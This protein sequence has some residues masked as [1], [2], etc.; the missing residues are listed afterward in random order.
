M[1]ENITQDPSKIPLTQNQYKGTPGAYDAEVCERLLD[2]WD[3][4][5]ATLNP[6]VLT[7]NNFSEY[8]QAFVGDIA[9]IGSQYKSM[10]AN[11]EDLVADID[12]S[13]QE[14]QGVSS[15][16]EL[17]NM[18]MYQH[19]YNANSRYITAVDQMLEDLLAKLG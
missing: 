2:A 9:T 8:Y 16:E 10:F 12:D 15:D 11:Q 5:F 13:R 17:S 1:N 4:D 3:E 19:A 18:I 7:S 14:V 6:N